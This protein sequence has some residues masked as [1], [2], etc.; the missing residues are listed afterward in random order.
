MPSESILKSAASSHAHTA[1]RSSLKQHAVCFT[2]GAS[3]EDEE[4]SLKHE[5]TQGGGLPQSEGITTF[6]KR[7]GHHAI[8][9]TKEY[10][11][12]FEDSDEE[13]GEK[14]SSTNEEDEEIWED[15]EESSNPPSIDECE[16]FQRV[17]SKTDL[18]PRRS[19]LASMLSRTSCPCKP[20]SSHP[21]APTS[22]RHCPEVNRARPIVIPTSTV[23]PPALSPRTTRRNMLSVEL[24]ESLRKHL[25]RYHEVYHPTTD[26][27]LKRRHKA[28]DMA[29]IRHFPNNNAPETHMPTNVSQSI[30]TSWSH[31]YFDAGPQEY[32]QR[33]W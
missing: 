20:V 11:S 3:P 19:L 32:H 10:E 33:G 31:N 27:T 22:I 1:A 29:K 14:P 7:F 23:H 26:A 9:A 8:N 17:D 4:S 28:Q 6:N 13:E 24:T 15:V 25:L 16:M 18:V 21:E 5:N 2:L 12:V 30:E